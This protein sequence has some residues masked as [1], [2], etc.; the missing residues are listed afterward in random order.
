VDGNLLVGDLQEDHDIVQKH[1]ERT[2]YIYN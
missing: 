2:F 1:H